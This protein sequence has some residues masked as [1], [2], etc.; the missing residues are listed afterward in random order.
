LVVGEGRRAAYSL[1]LSRGLIRIALEDIQTEW[2]VDLSGD[3]EG[4]QT[5][6]RAVIEAKEQLSQAV[7]CEAKHFK[8]QRDLGSLLAQ[9]G[10]L[11]E[12][13]AH[14]LAAIR[15]HADPT[16]YFNLG[17]VMSQR[18]KSQEA[19]GYYTQALKLA[20]DYAEARR[21]LDLLLAKVDAADHATVNL[22]T[23]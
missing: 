7:H 16:V 9:E 1:L 13:A 22:K 14:Y 23:R 15:T 19:I 20:P 18:G 11:E 8:A 21:S 3:G 6:R 10:R 2:G 4:I 5:L 12:A 17:E